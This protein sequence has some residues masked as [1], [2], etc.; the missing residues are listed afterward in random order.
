MA[1]PTLDEA[2]QRLE[3]ITKAISDEAKSKTDYPAFNLTLMTPEG[4]NQVPF[5]SCI[6]IPS[7]PDRFLVDLAPLRLTVAFVPGA[8]AENYCLL[9]LLQAAS[10]REAIKTVEIKEDSDL[11]PIVRLLRDG[12]ASYCNGFDVIEAD[13][14][15]SR[16]RKTDFQNLLVDKYDG[17]MIFRYYSKSL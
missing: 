4:E 17:N 7:V 16:L 5:L 14:V 9:A 6:P 10:S 15:F 2:T 11:I 12:E 8:E 1:L 13:D 3:Q